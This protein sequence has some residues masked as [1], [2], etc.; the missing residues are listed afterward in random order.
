VLG[1]AYKRDIDD[2]RE[3]PALDIIALL[4]QKGGLVEYHDPYAPHVEAREWPAAV[5]MQSVPLSD[6]A[7]TQADC[8]VIVTD[9]RVFDY[10]QILRHARLIVD[11]RNAI[12]PPNGRVFKLGAPVVAAG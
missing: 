2:I 6:Q 10:E 7:L 12:K 4:K 8:V 3:S 5:E 11:T 9:H 1:I